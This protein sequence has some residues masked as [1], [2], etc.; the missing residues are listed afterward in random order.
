M[1][2]VF[3]PD[4]APYRGGVQDADGCVHGPDLD[5]GDDRGSSRL[6]LDDVALFAEDDL[7]AARAPGEEGE[8][9]TE[10]ARGDEETGFLAH[11]RRG[12]RFEPSTVGS[13][14]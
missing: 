3:L 5:A 13:S 9:V 11:A 7:A 4:A 12:A 2:D 6:V 8:L 10:G 14:P 1:V